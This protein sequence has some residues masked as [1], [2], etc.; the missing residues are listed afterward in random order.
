MIKKLIWLIK[1]QEKIA[2]LVNS[3]EKKENK[4]NDDFS[5][6]GVPDFQKEYVEEL[7]NGNSNKNQRR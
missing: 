4:G 5:T 2:K 6:D 1:N 7:L 3:P